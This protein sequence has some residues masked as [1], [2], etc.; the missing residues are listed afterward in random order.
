[1]KVPGKC[2]VMLLPALTPKLI[3]TQ[4]SK[5]L[6]PFMCP[7]MFITLFNK[8]SPMDSRVKQ[9]KPVHICIACFFKIHF[10]IIF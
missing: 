5:V 1:M 9:L 10:N 3:V 2:Y 7:Q 4:L 6:A 8:M